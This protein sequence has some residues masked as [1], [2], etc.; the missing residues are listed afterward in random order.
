MVREIR[1]GASGL[2][3]SLRLAATERL[4]IAVRPDLSVAVVAPKGVG[5]EEVDQ[6]VVRRWG[7]IAKQQQAFARLHP[8]PVPRRFVSGETHL[9]LGRQYRLRI[10]AGPHGVALVPPY[11]VATLRGRHS[12]NQIANALM[13]WYDGQAKRAFTRRIGALSRR[14]PWLFQPAPSFRIRRMEARWGS[15]GPAGVVTLNSLLVMA[16]VACIDYVIVH[17]LVH[18]IELRHSRRFYRL[19]ERAV[20]GWKAI[21]DR[22]NRLPIT[23]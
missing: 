4:T 2:S 3:Y 14:F 23:G 13:E 10:R 11:F 6:R 22:L 5:P 17:E 18:R 19:L 9:Y 15:C 21:R 12:P 16:P 20:P 8:L 7:W 1:V